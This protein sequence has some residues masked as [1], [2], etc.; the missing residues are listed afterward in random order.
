MIYSAGPH[1]FGHLL[2]VIGTAKIEILAVNIAATKLVP[3]VLLDVKLSLRS[4]R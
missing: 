2:E 1:L 4:T 3:V